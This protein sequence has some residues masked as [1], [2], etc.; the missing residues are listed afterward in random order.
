MPLNILFI[1]PNQNHIISPTLYEQEAEGKL[2][3]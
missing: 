1:F 2:Q 3:D